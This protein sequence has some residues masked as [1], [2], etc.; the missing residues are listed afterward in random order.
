MR[1]WAGLLVLIAVAAAA[2]PASA[3][4]VPFSYLD[5]HLNPVGAAR[6]E[7][8]LVIHAFDLAHELQVEPPER[9]IDA[10][11]LEMRLAAIQTMLGARFRISADGEVLTPA[12]TGW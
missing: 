4:P 3:H 9:I 10:S 8:T 11:V 2:P 12:W 6:L 7:G 1:W 5:L